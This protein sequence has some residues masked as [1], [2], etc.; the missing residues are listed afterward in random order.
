MSDYDEFQAYLR[1]LT[2]F[3]MQ[4]FIRGQRAKIS[5]SDRARRF[6]VQIELSSA[7]MGVFDFV[8]FGLD[9]RGQLSDDRFMVFFNQMRAPGDAIVLEQLSDK[10]ARFALDLDALPPAISR[11]VFTVSVDGAGTMR[12][13]NSSFLSLSEA[14]TSTPLLRYD[15]NG[16]DFDTET[17]LMICEIYRKDGQWRFWAQGQG[18][19]G[20]LSALLKHFGGQE[21]EESVQNPAAQPAAQP[22]PQPSAAAP[23][24][25]SPAQPSTAVVVTPPSPA[26]SRPQNALQKLIDDAPSGGTLQM[27]RGEWQGPIFIDKPLVLDGGD[28]VVWAQNGPVVRVSSV[29]VTLRDLEI[30]ATAPEATAP[31]AGPH[32]DVALW[33][34]AGANAQL[35][36]VRVRG[37]IVGVAATQGPWKLPPALDLGEFAAR[38]DNSFSFEIEVPHACDLKTSVAGISIVPPR[39][40][41]GRAGLEVRVTGVGNDIFL[42]GHIELWSGGVGRTIPLSGRSISGAAPAR[43]VSLW[44]VD[45][46]QNP[47]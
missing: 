16:P 7:R 23:P 32:F 15:F 18:F 33:I 43:G 45:S 8:C 19:A 25:S 42:A 40:E 27:T 28:A 34:E 5:Q 47:A 24:V 3:S 22:A 26:V 39:V 38:E 30:E 17:A 46:A 37:E 4:S 35:H 36:N 41:A 11:L 31:D 44:R 2:D 6:A 9:E 13:L 1:S 10:T 20:N 29:G 21:I 12:D 14:G